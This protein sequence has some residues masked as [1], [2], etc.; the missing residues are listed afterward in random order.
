MNKS[1]QYFFGIALLGIFTYSC[2][3]NS[4]NI[5]INNASL[6]LS[7][8]NN[9]ESKRRITSEFKEYWYAGKAEITS[10]ALSQERYGELREGTAVTVFVT[11]DFK[12]DKQ[13]KSD[14]YAKENIPVIKFN[15]TKKFLTG[16]YPYSIMTSVFNPVQ[17][18]KHALKVANSVQEWCGQVYMQLNNREEYEFTGHSYFESEGDQ[19]LNL[20]KTWL[21]DEIWNRI[22][23]NP[24]ELPTGDIE[25]IPSFEFLRLR[26]KE[27]RAYEATASFKQ[28]DSLSIYEIRYPSLGRDLVIYFNSSFPFEIEKWEETNVGW[29]GTNESMT[30]T[31]KRIKRIRS[32]YWTKNSNSDTS[33]RDSLGLNP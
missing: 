33:L 12:P 15:G 27:A 20:P 11:E 13:V 26:H 32:A 8:K 10:Y 17:T 30:T 18:D 16:I 4:G 21:E 9:E 31:A 19:N 23:I 28:G 1:F 2:N 24:E 5:S 14:R 22:R 25:M 7:E 3:N 29:R 6:V